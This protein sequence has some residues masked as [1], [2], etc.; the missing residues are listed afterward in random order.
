MFAYGPFGPPRREAQP[1][2]DPPVEPSLRRYFVITGAL[3][4]GY[5]SIYTLLADLRDEYGFSEAQ[6]GVIAAA[7]FFAGFIAQI[8]LARQADSGRAGMMVRGGILLAAA[9]MLACAITN[10]YWSFVLARACLGLG[11]GAAGPAL[12]RLV[13]LRAPDDVGANLGRQASWDIGGFV[14]GP[15]IAAV[16]AE[17]FGLRAPFVVLGGL[18][19]VMLAMTA[20]LDLASEPVKAPEGP[21][22]GLL[23]QRPLLAALA[24]AIAFYTTIGVF[25]SVWAVLLR[26]RGAE[27]WLIG[28]TLSIFTIPMI[29]LAPIGGRVA[30]QRGP[31]RTVAV[32]IGVATACTLSYG[33][34][35]ALWVLLL[36][37]IVH[38][39]ADSF[40]MPGNQVGVAI[41][42]PPHQT[43]A[44][45]G[46]L[47]ASGLATAG[48]V[49][50][51]SGAIYDHA[52]AFALFTGAAVWMAACL[53]VAL[54]LGRELLQ[55]V[56]VAVEPPAAEVTSPPSL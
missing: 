55:P 4:L 54:V 7:G 6:L 21:S 50:L 48:V 31:L 56:G 42:T 27:T 5:G 8:A 28:L 46:L 51:V 14:L 20:S 3:A 19:L 17:L 30:Q 32:S 11:S 43:A 33:I 35:R 25:E 38:A 47:G 23:R 37:S 12:R 41:A 44:G 13:I 34:F 45:Q 18:F 24:A 9:S 36:I 29:F 2:Y 16:I 15:L 40:T 52:G 10:E 26:D 1:P 22:V 49:G 39:V 53:A